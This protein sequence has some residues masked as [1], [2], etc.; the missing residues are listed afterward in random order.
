MTCDCEAL[1]D[2]VA[3]LESELGLR[4][5]AELMHALALVGRELSDRRAPSASRI[6]AAL[7]AAKGRPVSTDNLMRAAPNK[8][9]HEDE[10]LRN[11][12]SVYVY[13]L[14]KALGKDA[15]ETVYGFG[16]R[17]SAKGMAQAAA[18]LGDAT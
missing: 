14:R 10:R 9:Y 4:R 1:R 16:Y 11:I 7:Y 8:G 13:Y 12:V 17:L 5:Q 2:R 6:L 18:M 3:E 15:I